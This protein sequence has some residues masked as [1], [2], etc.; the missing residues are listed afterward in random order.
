MQGSDG[1]L[2]VYNYTAQQGYYASTFATHTTGNPGAYLMVQSD[3][4]LAIYNGLTP[5]WQRPGFQSGVY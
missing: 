4:N 2:V 3:G 1:N 5:I